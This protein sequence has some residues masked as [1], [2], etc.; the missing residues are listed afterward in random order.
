MLRVDLI[1][2]SDESLDPTPPPVSGRFEVVTLA[3]NGPDFPVYMGPKVMSCMRFRDRTFRLD[4]EPGPLG[5][6]NHKP[7]WEVGGLKSP[8]EWKPGLVRTPCMGPEP[9]YWA[10]RR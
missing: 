7:A 4:S 9:P 5:G 3:P 2:E 1:E 10:P 6:V 8:E